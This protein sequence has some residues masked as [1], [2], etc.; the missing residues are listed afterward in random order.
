MAFPKNLSART[1]PFTPPPT[2]V[3]VVPFQPIKLLVGA[4]LVVECVN[5][6]PATSRAPTVSSAS[7]SGEVTSIARH[8]IP[9]GS[10]WAIPV[11]VASAAPVP[12]VLNVPAAISTDPYR[13]LLNT[14]SV[15]ARG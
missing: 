5:V 11:A 2:D 6:P 12:A 3:R 15:N 13:G 7:T 10:H 14:F 4:E 8:R 1:P 9:M